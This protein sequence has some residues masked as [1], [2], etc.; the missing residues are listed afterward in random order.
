MIIIDDHSTDSTSEKVHHFI[1]D[2]PNFTLIELTLSSPVVSYK[3]KS[4][5]RGISASTGNVIITTDGDCRVGKNW[6]GA[7][8]EMI[9]KTGAICIC[10]P[11]T[12]IDDSKLFT[13][14]QIME[15]A[16]LLGSGAATITLGMPGMCNG[17][18]LIYKKEAFYSVQGFKSIDTIASGDDELLMHKLLKKYPGDVLFLKSRDAIVSTKANQ[19][20]AEF[21]N[22]RKRWAGKWSYYK[23]MTVK[24]LAIFIFTFNLYIA[25]GGFL[26]LLE[27]L[28]WKVYLFHFLL[29]ALFESIFII[30]ILIFLKKK[31]DIFRLLLLQIV[32]PFYTVFFGIVAN[33]GGYD[34]KD[35]K[36]NGK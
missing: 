1:K 17:A 14:F 25:F 27:I 19:D 11:V 21:Y 3:K 30:Q 26:V 33:F 22:Q 24:A 7:I 34:W 29:K 8:N 6:L 15:L 36:V 32:Y 18:N 16:A 5:E 35:R 20:L 31:I 23:S 9:V 2:R 4:I 12:Y 13:G 28:T 10:G